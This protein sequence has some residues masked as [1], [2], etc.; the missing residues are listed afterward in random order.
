M[1][2]LPSP[3]KSPVST[4]DQ[5]VGTVPTDTP[6]ATVPFLF[7]SHIATLPLLSRQRMSVLPS[8]FKSPAP[9]I[10][11]LVGTFPSDTA[12]ETVPPFIFQSAPSQAVLRQ[13]MPLPLLP[14]IDQVVETFAT[15][16]L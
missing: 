3:L 2:L 16:R 9:T 15:N 7:N 12:E 14:A 4:I 13:R 1:S 6:E 5:A 8:P 10:D 11:Q